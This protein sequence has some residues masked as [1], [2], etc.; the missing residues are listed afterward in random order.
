MQSSGPKRRLSN[1]AADFETTT[2]ENDCRVWSWGAED[3]FSG[4]YVSGIDLDSF[5]DWVSMRQSRLYFHNLKFDGKFILP[6]LFNNDYK[7]TEDRN[8]QPGEFTTSIDKVGTWYRIVVRWLNG[9]K[10]EIWDSLKKLPM[11]IAQMAKAFDLPVSKGEIDYEKPRP[12]G[13]IPTPEEDE[14]QRTDCHILASALRVVLEEGADKMTVGSDSLSHFKSLYGAK[15]WASTFPVLDPDTDAELRLSYRGG[16]TYAAKRFRRQMLKRG[17]T[18][19][20]NSLYPSVMYNA[21]LPIG[22]P[23][24]IEEMPTF[25]PNK[26]YIFKVSIMARLKE[27]HLPCI[28]TKQ[29][30]KFVATEYLEVIDEPLDVWVTSVD[31]KLWNDHYDI[32]IVEFHSGYEFRGAKGIFQKYIDYWMK[33]KKTS[34]G[35]LRTLA[36][37]HLNSLYG[38]FGT[39]PLHQPQIPYMKEDGTVRYREGEETREESVYVPMAAFITAYAREITIRAAQAHYDDFVYADTDSLHLLGT[40]A[41]EGLWVH[42][43]DLGAWKHEYDWSTGVFSRAKC[44]T[45]VKVD[46]TMSTPIVKRYETHIAGLPHSVASVVRLRHH[47]DG[48]VFGGNESPANEPRKLMP[49]TVPGGVV[50]KPGTFKLN[51]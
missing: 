49:K 18:Y 48:Y 28:Q 14:Y 22:D 36:K 6:W 20:V 21:F 13:Y 16:W 15:R 47:L 30:S 11:S 4:K 7:W 40:G 3:V 33:I 24:I 29:N 39:S 32:D 35:G 1:W 44:Y 12:L 43:H 51:V 42:P 45:E 23:T 46:P 50:L 34:K 9:R 27:N 31:W 25:D 26:L 19:D 17:S 41:R 8:P 38:K 37:L 5:V 2:D 10:T